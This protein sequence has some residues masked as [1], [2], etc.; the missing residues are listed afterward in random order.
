MTDVLHER[1]EPSTVADVVLDSAERE[2]W[3]PAENEQE[4]KFRVSGVFVVP[5]LAGRDHH[6]VI[7]RARRLDSTYWDT[8]DVR[9]ARHGHTL[10]YRT[11][12]DGSDPTWTLKLE[13]AQDGALL[14]RREV[15]SDGGPIEPPQR[16]AEAVSGITGGQALVMVAHLR[17]D[18]QQYSV[19]S[20]QGHRLLTIEDDRVVVLEGSASIGSFREVEVELA[21]EVEGRDA[22]ARAVK[23]LRQAGAGKPDPTSKLARVL[24]PGAARERVPD[25]DRK[26]TIEDVVRVAVLDGLGQLLVHDPG[27]RLNLGEDDVHDARVATRRLRSNLRTLRPVLDR[28]V[29][30]R[31]R[32]ELSW[33]GALLGEV[34][35]RDVMRSTF[36][37]S[38]AESPGLD[39]HELLAT[40]AAERTAAHRR[41]VES[42]LGSRWRSMVDSLEAAALM[43]PLRGTT[44][45]MDGAAKIARS[46][47]RKSFARCE[48]RVAAAQDGTTSWHE[49][50][51]AFKSTRYAAELFE[52]VLGR[53]SH[54][55]AGATEDIQE[56]LGD[57]QDLV[58]A[59]EW[60]RRHT[61]HPQMGAVA[62][63]LC[64]KLDDPVVGEP[65]QWNR[66]WKRARRAA[67]RVV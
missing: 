48:R 49:V 16:L 36:V 65:A 6:D 17:S 40:I 39:G 25:L 8:A 61:D 15:E 37:T 43:P 33:A 58:V 60:L 10:R 3:A 66:L 13:G 20:S 63:Q 45:P 59:C 56:Q 53:A 30:D 5:P 44:A 26:S 67:S 1:S 35:D 62:R 50:R 23:R 42:M 64:D 27:V 47:L 12:D 2:I 57:V 31:L 55:F 7:G 29:I 14:Q 34:R 9:L 11:A 4:V 46:L 18:Q 52:P 28:T 51:K 19:E 38:L 32:D 54:T 24:G 21:D 41:L 22:L